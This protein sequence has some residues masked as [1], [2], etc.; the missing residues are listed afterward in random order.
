VLAAGF[1]TALF[2]F[3]RV[4]ILERPDSHTRMLMFYPAYGASPIPPLARAT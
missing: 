3:T 1:S 2:T 4:F